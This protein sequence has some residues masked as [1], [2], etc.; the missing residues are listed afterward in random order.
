M[1]M[2]INDHR[3]ISNFSQRFN[4]HPLVEADIET[5]EQRTKLDILEDAIF[6][7]CKLIYPDIAQ[8]ITHCEQISFYMKKNIL[9]T[10]RETPNGIF[11]QVKSKRIF[12][13]I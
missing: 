13:E 10:F 7:V 6:L 12:R 3:Q 8:R 1:L 4:I 9:I 5:T 11:E 2:K